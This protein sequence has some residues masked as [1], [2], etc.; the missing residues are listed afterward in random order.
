MQSRARPC[1]W[2]RLV[3]AILCLPLLLF[4]GTLNSLPPL[5]HGRTL[6]VDPG[7]EVREEVHGEVHGMLPYGSLRDGLSAASSGDTLLLADG[8]YAGKDNRNLVLPARDLVMTSE[9]GDPRRCIIDCE[10]AGRAFLLGDAHACRDFTPRLPGASTD[11]W[12]HITIRGITIMR[13]DA[14]EGGALASYKPFRPTMVNCVFTRNRAARTGGAV[15][16]CHSRADIQDCIF[17]QN[18]A[19]E[20][21][22]ALAIT[23]CS[24]AEMHGCTLALNAAP[25]GAGL[26]FTGSTIPKLDHCIV[27]FNGP[28]Q[29]LALGPSQRQRLGLELTWCNLYG[30]A[31][32]DAP[33]ALTDTSLTRFV[34]HANP[35]F[36]DLGAGDYRLL[37]TSPCAMANNASGS[38]IGA[39]DTGLE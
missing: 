2:S 19:G 23:R 33:P 39:R 10:G 8:R 34:L 5:A 30:N 25:Q 26:Y 6:Y 15:H 32:G 36:R 29:G 28:G 21:G 9:S 12:P 1:S 22:G 18:T 20:A 14:E 37:P 38:S 27:A 31:G 7:G 4:A 17:E 16:L 13:G 3:P 11:G 24:A 35:L